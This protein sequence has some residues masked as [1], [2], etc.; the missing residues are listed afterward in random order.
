V[1]QL[2]VYYMRQTLW[3][4]WQTDLDKCSIARSLNRC[5]SPMLSVGWYVSGNWVHIKIR[6]VYSSSMSTKRQFWLCPT[7]GGSWTGGSGV[8]ITRSHQAVRYLLLSLL[9]LPAM[10]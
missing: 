5:C 7:G 2:M 8:L 1:S 9:L 6:F 3:H 4:T 10:Q